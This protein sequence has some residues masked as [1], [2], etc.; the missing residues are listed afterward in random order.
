MYCGDSR[1]FAIC[2]A[3]KSKA[4]S[5]QVEITP[6]RDLGK[7]KKVEKPVEKETELENV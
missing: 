7:G 4:V 6:F 2:C 5:G 1:Y 3:R